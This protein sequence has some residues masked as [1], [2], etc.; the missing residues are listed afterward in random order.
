MQR[1]KGIFRR[2]IVKHLNPPIAHLTR[3]MGG[4]YTYH[5]QVYISTISI[6]LLGKN[7]S[8]ILIIGSFVFLLIS[9]V[10]K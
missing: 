7:R 10:F 1:E 3:V 8:E 4:K 6:D 9:V 2:D 5:T